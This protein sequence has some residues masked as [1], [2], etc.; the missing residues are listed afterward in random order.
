MMIDSEQE[1]ENARAAIADARATGAKTL[2][3]HRA[4]IGTLTHLPEELGDL[5]TVT[6]LDIG[7]TQV[8]DISVLALLGGLKALELTNTQVTDIAPLAD[9][10]YLEEV[11]LGGTGV[12]DISA[13]S[14]LVR[15]KLLRL[16]DTGVID[17]TTLS[18]LPTL[19][20]L[21]L[22]RAAIRDLRP[23]LRLRRNFEGSDSGQLTFR[24][25]AATRLDDRIR[26][27]S[28]ISDS[29]VRAQELFDYLE[30]WEPPWEQEPDPDELA[31]IEVVD[32]RLEIGASHPTEAECDEALKQVIHER[33]RGR[34]GDLA[35]L[36]G[37][38][39]PRLAGR[40]RGLYEKLDRPFAELDM[41]L[42]H[43]DVEDL[44]DLYERRGERQGDDALTPDV[45]DALADVA[46]DGPGLTLDNPDVEKL[47][48]RKRRFAASAPP[49]QVGAAH[50][51]MSRLVAGAQ[52]VFGERLRALEG[53]MDGR[54]SLPSTAVVQEAVH[55]NVLLRIGQF[56]LGPAKVIFLGAAGNALWQFVHEGWPVITIIAESYGPAFARWFSAALSSAKEMVGV[57]ANVELKPVP[58]MPRRD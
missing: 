40:A 15:L 25:C 16:D 30:T 48:E 27:I 32:G 1:F 39:Y 12:T 38:L 58:R 41:L 49:A 11:Y 5:E 51:E 55:R 9:L 8:S 53:R 6:I 35:Q 24:D 21:V 22:D 50:D 54:E 37:N 17:I 43:L 2:Y 26:E 56:V 13:L 14:D 45:V 47:E 36:A 33:L 57:A 42:V 29:A 7:E 20:R 3:L 28:E 44:A 18:H 23:L 46:R 10:P 19:N 34:A 31:P 52:A 4:E